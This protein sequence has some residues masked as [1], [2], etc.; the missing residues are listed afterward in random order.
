MLGHISRFD[1]LTEIRI[2]VLESQFARF[3]RCQRA[4]GLTTRAFRIRHSRG[5]KN[6]H[7]LLVRGAAPDAKTSFS[8]E[9]RES[10]FSLL[11]L[12]FAQV[13][14]PSASTILVER[15]WSP[16]LP[17]VCGNLT[18]DGPFRGN[19]V[20]SSIPPL[21]DRSCRPKFESTLKHTPIATPEEK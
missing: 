14:V 7:R 1:P 20:D 6:R 8:D 5:P 13:Q 21:D 12:F 4:S 9:L 11:F 2:V 18:S 16:L 10:C 17:R 3:E 15:L 19:P